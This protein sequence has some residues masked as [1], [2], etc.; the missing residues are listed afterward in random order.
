ML[1]LLKVLLLQKVNCFQYSDETSDDKHFKWLLIGLITTTFAGKYISSLASSCR[2]SS[3]WVSWE[4]EEEE[5]EEE[6]AA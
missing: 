5:E 4:E 2:R 6:A 1:K 3:Q